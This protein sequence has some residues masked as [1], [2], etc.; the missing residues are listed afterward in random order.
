MHGACCSSVRVFVIIAK[1]LAVFSTLSIIM[2]MII[3]III[4]INQSIPFV[5]TG[6]KNF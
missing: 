5:Y 2:I 4:I 6:F 3:I 1:S